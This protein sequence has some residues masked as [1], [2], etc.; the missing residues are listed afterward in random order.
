MLLIK[1]GWSEY[2]YKQATAT[3]LK[4]QQTEKQYE[5]A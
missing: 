1:T 3:L 5:A 4:N 2:F